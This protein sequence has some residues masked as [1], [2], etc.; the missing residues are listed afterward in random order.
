MSNREWLEGPETLE[1]LEGKFEF[2]FFPNGLKGQ[3]IS[4][5]LSLTSASV[6]KARG[7]QQQL[8]G[9]AAKGGVESQ[10]TWS[11]RARSNALFAE[12]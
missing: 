8:S 7:D 10:A 4:V 6:C 5:S 3:V 11:P 9:P 12:R 2:G 1:A